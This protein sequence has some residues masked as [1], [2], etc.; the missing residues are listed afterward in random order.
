[1][2]DDAMGPAEPRPPVD[3]PGWIEPESPTEVQRF[4]S[5]FWREVAEHPRRL[6]AAVVVTTVGIAAVVDVQHPSASAADNSL[7][8]LDQPVNPRQ[9]KS[10]TPPTPPLASPVLRYRALAKQAAATCPGLPPRVLFAIAEVETN[11]GRNT[12][13]SSAGAIGPMQFLPRTWRAYGTDGDGD[14]RSDITNPADAVHTAARHLCAN[15]GAQPQRLR[16][17]IWNYNR[18]EEYVERVVA[19]AEASG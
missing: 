19:L 4:W 14:G 18:S 5:S 2:Y 11:L 1:M 6:V 15:G 7:A 13:V 8:P 3:P 16:A 10:P 17:A 12:S 9:E